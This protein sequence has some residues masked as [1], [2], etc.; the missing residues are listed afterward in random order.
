MATGDGPGW[1]RE[2][3]LK[4]ALAPRDHRTV[5]AHPLVRRRMAGRPRRRRLETRYFDTPERLLWARGAAFRVRRSE[6]G[7]EQT[8]KLAEA[9][10]G[11]LAD[12][13]EW[14]CPVE[15]FLPRPELLPAELAARAG[16]VPGAALVPLFETRFLRR[17]GLLRWRAVPG[18]LV[19]LEVALDHGWILAGDR[20]ERISE[21]ELEVRRGPAAAAFGLA[22][23]LGR[24]VPL[25]PSIADKAMRGHMLGGAPPPPFHAVR[26]S[27]EPSI[28][29]GAAFRRLMQTVLAH[30][31]A[32]EVALRHGAD[33]EAVHQLRVAMRRAVVALALF[34]DLLPA[35]AGQSFRG[36]IKGVLGGLAEMRELDVIVAELLGPLPAEEE[37]GLPALAERLERAR[38][39]ARGAVNG[40]LASPAYGGL[41][42]ELASWLEREGWR[43]GAEPALLLR[44]DLPVGEHAARMLDRSWKRLARAGRRASE[45]DV[46]GRHA[47]RLAAKRMRYATDFFAPLYPAR[48]TEAWL[49]RLRRLQNL[50]GEDS[51]LAS[52]RVLLARLVAATPRAR[53]EPLAA[54]AGFVLG[55]H[56]HRLADLPER[57][58]REL[59]K[60]RE[61]SR[62]W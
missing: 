52:A 38:V 56:R 36:R 20:R 32:S 5:F 30:W 57:L 55:W 39:R 60:L 3:E 47:L 2:I 41:L 34:R 37:T 35:A 18:G 12:R 25:R 28:A 10:G 17:S 61:L 14:S 27:L 49:R 9:G 48:K 54:A 26:P 46:A 58:D 22:E 59:A 21:L 19:E 11:A 13:L 44:Q 7:F 16:L 6:E 8:L 1:P 23:A 4:L 15:D 33:A 62:F 53:R 24:A 42:L 40:L 29:G 50:L 31:L 43:E 45:L 51:D